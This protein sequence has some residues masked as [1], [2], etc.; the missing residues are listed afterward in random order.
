[1]AHG[2]L[3][4][5]ATDSQLMVVPWLD[6]VVDSI[7]YEVRSQYVA[8]FWLNVLGPTATWILRRLVLGFDR[9]PLG[10]ELDLGETANA[11][12]LS[13]TIRTAN[14]VMRSPTPRVR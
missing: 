10:Y 2:Q 4:I 14:A 1:M 9:Y 11:L 5:S 7:G 8:L 3:E 6:P 13:Y 12:G